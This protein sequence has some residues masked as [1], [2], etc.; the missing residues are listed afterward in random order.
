MAG[1]VAGGRGFHLLHWDPGRRGG[2]TAHPNY[3]AQFGSILIRGRRFPGPL[4]YQGRE[5]IGI[6]PRAESTHA[7][8]SGVRRSLWGRAA[9]SAE[10]PAVSPAA[11]RVLD[12]VMTRFCSSWM[13]AMESRRI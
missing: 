7:L 1:A 4:P 9:S 8:S 11:A 2:E 10:M 13:V 6:R 12:W 5:A 3:P